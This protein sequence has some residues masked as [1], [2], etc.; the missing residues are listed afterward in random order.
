MG[1][2]GGNYYKRC[3]QIAICTLLIEIFAVFSDRKPRQRSG[4]HSFRER[5]GRRNEHVEFTV[6]RHYV[7]VHGRGNWNGGHQYQMGP[8][9]GPER[10]ERRPEWLPCSEQGSG[11]IALSMGRERRFRIY[12]EFDHVAT[13]ES[14]LLETQ[15]GRAKEASR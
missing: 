7:H 2:L 12:R 5:N 6:A 14:Q 10:L 13:G 9:G 8:D 11:E 15:L 1:K 4:G 3:G